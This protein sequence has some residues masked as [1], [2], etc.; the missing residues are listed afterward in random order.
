MF[1]EVAGL[2]AHPLL[3]H[4]SVVLIPLFAFAAAGYA[5]LPGVRVRI[6]WLVAA[7]AL[8]APVAAV[9]TK[10][11][12]DALLARLQRRNLTSPEILSKIASHQELGN[13]T[14]WAAILLGLVVAAY[15]VLLP[16]PIAPGWLP[17]ALS[18]LARLAPDQDP[19]S[20]AAKPPTPVTRAAGQIVIAA[21]SDTTA[22][23]TYWSL[24]AATVILAFA[25]LYLAIRTGDS[26]ARIVWSGV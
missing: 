16:G 23:V 11:S 3:V 8:A 10:L 20:P 18:H 21:R 19:S 14:M 12:G 25:S 13:R 5:L 6:R 4:V 17:E 24:T 15:L 2:P 9:F 26:G 1:E 22:S 7:L